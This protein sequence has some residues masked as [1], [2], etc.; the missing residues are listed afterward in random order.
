ML[1]PLF[2]ILKRGKGAHHFILSL[3]ELPF[4]MG[5]GY[6]INYRK[7]IQGIYNPQIPI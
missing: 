5:G 7:E 6:S 1:K 2:G 4:A 3:Y